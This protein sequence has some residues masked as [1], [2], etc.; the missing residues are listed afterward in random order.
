MMIQTKSSLFLKKYIDDDS[1]VM[2]DSSSIKPMNDYE[3]VT[4]ATGERG[5]VSIQG[6]NR[7]GQSGSLVLGIEGVLYP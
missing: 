2:I 3:T 4:K 6:A 7:Y 5:E 1:S